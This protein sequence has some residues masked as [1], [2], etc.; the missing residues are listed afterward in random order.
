[1]TRQAY[2]KDPVTGCWGWT[3][4]DRGRAEVSVLRGSRMTPRGAKYGS[5]NFGRKTIRRGAA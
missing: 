5:G 2:I 4:V 1:M 3:Y